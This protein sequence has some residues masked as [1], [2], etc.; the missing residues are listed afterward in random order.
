MIQN[1][2]NGAALGFG[3][4][5]LGLGC[6][7][8]A[9]PSYRGEPLVSVSGQ[10]EAPLS[11]GPVEVGVLWLIAAGDFDVVC[12][13]EATTASGEPSACAAAC[14]EVTCAGL[15][16]WGDCAEACADV[17]SVIVEAKTSASPFIRGG[18]AQTAPAV[19][20]FPARFSLDIL[21]PPPDEVLIG[22]TTGE[23]LA[24]GEFVALDPAGDPWRIDFTEPEYPPWLLG[25]SETHLLVY[26]PEPIP[27]TSL[28]A[29]VIGSPLSE[30]YHL[31]E[32]S[33]GDEE[34]DGAPVLVPGDDL[35][36]VRLLIAPPDTIAWPL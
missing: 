16:A 13:G 26:A 5:L 7:G 21:E 14:G 33:P 34:G 29:N 4:L 24:I 27:E 10:V 32:V 1:G 6:D 22:S 31:L 12:T 3:L 17:T 19:G 28:W 11:L 30:G 2:K 35:D 8:Q 9:D 15:E 23:R 25:G 20:E 18:V 36:D